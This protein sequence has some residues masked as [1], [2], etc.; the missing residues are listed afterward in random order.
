MDTFLI[1]SVGNVES[2]PPPD[3][4]KGFINF[5]FTYIFEI[6]I[7]YNKNNFCVKYENINI[8]KDQN[9]SPYETIVFD[10]KILAP[11]IRTVDFGSS[12]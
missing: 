3:D 12:I 2:D 9:F 4:F 11:K 5:T 1:I 7:I 10:I 6:K 8:F